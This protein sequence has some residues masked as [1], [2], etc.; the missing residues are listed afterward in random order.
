MTGM[1]DALLHHPSLYGAY[2]W[3]C[4]GCG[5]DVGNVWSGIGPEFLAAHQAEMLAAAGFGPVREAGAVALEEAADDFR[6]NRTIITGPRLRG[7]LR[8]RAVTVRGE[9]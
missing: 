5:A 9:S 4:S 7:W 8:A 6:G 1:A 3:T 2:E